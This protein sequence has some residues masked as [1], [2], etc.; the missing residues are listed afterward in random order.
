MGYFYVFN[1]FIITVINIS[2]INIFRS[3]TKNTVGLHP[4][5]IYDSVASKSMYGYSPVTGKK[6]LIRISVLY[7]TDSRLIFR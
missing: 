2:Q 7:R 6:T 3:K 4:F 5:Q 1:K